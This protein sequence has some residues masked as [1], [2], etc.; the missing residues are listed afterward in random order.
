MA[1]FAYLQRLLQKHGDFETAIMEEMKRPLPDF[2]RI[3][4]LKKQK[5]AMKQ[6]IALYREQ[7]LPSSSA[8]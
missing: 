5:L 4:E 3:T 2:A 7:A 6:Q 1:S 8:G